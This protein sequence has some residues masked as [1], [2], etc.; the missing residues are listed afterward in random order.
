MSK[1]RLLA[2]ETL[3]LAQAKAY[4]KKPK[5]GGAARPLY[6]EP[7]QGQPRKRSRMEE[8][9]QEQSQERSNTSEPIPSTSGSFSTS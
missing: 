9:Q 7:E 8:R 6:L 3:S 1:L 4:V 2:Y 5:A